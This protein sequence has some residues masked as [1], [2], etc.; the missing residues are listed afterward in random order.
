ML[1]LLCRLARDSRARS[2]LRQ[3]AGDTL[4]E[5]IAAAGSTLER[6]WLDFL[7]TGG[8]SLPDRGQPLLE[9]YG[10]RPDFAY[11]HRQTL[12]YIDGPHHDGKRR[13]RA[14]A[15]VTR[16]LEGAGYTV[17]RFGKDQTTWERIVC[18]YA[19]IFGPG[20]S[21]AG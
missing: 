21:L 4:D 1:D 17:V 7:V 11:T 20:T 10:T 15:E 8:Y 16:Q 6:K 12:V 5:L 9:E 14:D 3:G 2:G 13:R 19:W 18:E